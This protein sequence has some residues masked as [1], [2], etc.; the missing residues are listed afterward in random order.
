MASVAAGQGWEQQDARIQEEAADLGLSPLVLL[1]RQRRHQAARSLSGS[2]DP[3]EQDSGP[4]QGP[5]SV[6]ASVEGA[7]EGKDPCDGT[8]WP[9]PKLQWATCQGPKRL[10]AAHHQDQD[11]IVTMV[12]PLLSLPMEAADDFVYVRRV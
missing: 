6:E 10:T 11:E 3:D 4:L 7:E 12:D 9:P 1:L 5:E 2:E 8:R